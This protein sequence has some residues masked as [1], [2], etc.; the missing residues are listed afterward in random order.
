MYRNSFVKDNRLRLWAGFL[1][2]SIFLPLIQSFFKFMVY[3]VL[4]VADTLTA[5][6][7][8]CGVHWRCARFAPA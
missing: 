4:K 6:H 7:V 1:M 3:L 8:T 2:V 5:A